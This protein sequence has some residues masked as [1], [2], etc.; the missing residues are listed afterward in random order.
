MYAP[1]PIG[2][3]TTLKEKYDAIKTLLQHIKYEHH[4]MVTCVDL[5]MVHFL[6]GHFSLLSMLLGQQG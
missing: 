3:S 5:K 4:Q 1:T 6:L 2:H